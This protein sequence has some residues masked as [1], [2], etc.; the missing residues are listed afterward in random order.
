MQYLN[1]PKFV[2]YKG[3]VEEHLKRIPGEPFAIRLNGTQDK[4]EIIH[5]DTDKVIG[6]MQQGDD[7]RSIFKQL[8]KDFA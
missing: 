7:Y 5:I 6:E 1:N 8:T 3:N 2:N 4:I